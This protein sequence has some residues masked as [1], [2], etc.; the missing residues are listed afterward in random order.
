MCKTKKQLSIVS[1]R[2][3][4]CLPFRNVSNP[5]KCRIFNMIGI[6]KNHELLSDYF[7]FMHSFFKSKYFYFHI[8]IVYTIIF[9]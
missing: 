8:F 4:L 3:K 6:M 2:F 7:P 1:L 5:V 9:T